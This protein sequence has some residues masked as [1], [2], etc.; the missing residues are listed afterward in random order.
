MPVAVTQA[1]RD[2]GFKYSEGVQ[3]WKKSSGGF[4]F[5]HAQMWPTAH[6]DLA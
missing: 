3:G 1:L 5:V 4:G 2:A 6:S